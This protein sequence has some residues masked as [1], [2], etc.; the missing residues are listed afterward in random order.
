LGLDLSPEIFL[1]AVLYTFHTSM[2]M[3]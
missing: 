1:A 3:R 2:R